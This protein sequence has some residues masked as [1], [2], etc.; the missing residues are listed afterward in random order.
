MNCFLQERIRL[1]R[2]K[3]EVNLIFINQ[4]FITEAAQP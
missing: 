3:I 4:Q 1:Y 2:Q